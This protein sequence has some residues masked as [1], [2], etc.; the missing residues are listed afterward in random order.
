MTGLSEIMESV[1]K[2]LPFGLDKRLGKKDSPQQQAQPEGG[3][4]QEQSPGT[5]QQASGQIEIGIVQ[6]SGVDLASFEEV[7]KQV[8]AANERIVELESR[9]YKAERGTD[10]VKKENE[11]LKG[12]MDQT[13]ARILDMLSVYEVV[14]NQINPF[15][16]SSKVISSTMEQLQEELSTIKTQVTTISSDMKI[17]ARGKVDI[18]RLVRSSVSEADTK[19]RVDLT[20]LIRTA[21]QSKKTVKTKKDGI[22]YGP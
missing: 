5:S 8:Q 10:T 6:D 22:E 3:Q 14:S 4:P 1:T 13:D 18:T 12:R 2:S 17:L 21:V 9:L 15:V 16:G 11:L 7:K 19:R 20:K